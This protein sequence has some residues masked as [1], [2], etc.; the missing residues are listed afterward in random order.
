MSQRPDEAEIP[1]LTLLVRPGTAAPVQP[2]TPTPAQSE[3]ATPAQ[4]ETPAPAPVSPTIPRPGPMPEDLDIDLA[5]DGLGALDGQDMPHASAPTSLAPLETLMPP[6]QVTGDTPALRARVEQLV[7]EALAN[8]LPELRDQ[9]VRSVL[10]TLSD[11]R[12]GPGEEPAGD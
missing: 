12:P 5:L 4:S 9:L 10:R 11:G 3:T 8:R 7:D 6:T 2:G 1:T